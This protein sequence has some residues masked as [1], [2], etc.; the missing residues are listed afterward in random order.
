MKRRHNTRACQ[1]C[2]T[3]SRLYDLVEQS[4][5]DGFEP[6]P[7]WQAIQIIEHDCFT[8]AYAPSPIFRD[9]LLASLMR[10]KAAALQ[11]EDLF[12]CDE[13]P[14]DTW[15]AAVGVLITFWCA[16]KSLAARRAA[17][18][19]RGAV[20]QF[21]GALRDAHESNEWSQRSCRDYEAKCGRA[22]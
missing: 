10:A 13:A 8:F 2:A 7:L 15:F 1:A 6:Y 18:G 3:W 14:L 11:S 9:A 22:V 19:I 5:C 20:M 21:S 4:G 12:W 17:A 16:H